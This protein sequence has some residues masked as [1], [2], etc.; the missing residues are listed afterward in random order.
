LPRFV[1]MTVDPP[2]AIQG[3]TLIA[4][5][6]RTGR[7]IQIVSSAQPPPVPN[8]DPWNV[9]GF[10]VS[11]DGRTVAFG[12]QTVEYTRSSTV[13]PRTTAA[14]YLAPIDG[15]GAPRQLQQ[16][17]GEYPEGWVARF[18]PDGR[19]LVGNSKTWTVWPVDGGAPIVSDHPA[20]YPAAGVQWSPDG[21]RIALGEHYERTSSGVT[22]ILQFDAERRTLTRARGNGAG[23]MPG[24][25][26]WFSR[27]GELHVVAKR[28]LCGGPL[29]VDA[30]FRWGI[31]VRTENC[32]GIVSELAWWDTAT[33]PQTEHAL[34][35]TLPEGVTGVAW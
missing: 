35:L 20:G 14:I 6:R 25:A 15:S 9:T 32:S 30:S 23:S 12:V 33:G 11:P 7:Q 26:P 1:V 8:D 34:G 31:S 24:T 16:I 13:R 19:W 10:D 22:S 4:L 28:S 18:S 5:D 27:D 17:T 29:D 21:T 3:R 2:S